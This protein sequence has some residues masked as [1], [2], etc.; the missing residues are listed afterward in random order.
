M[1]N[2]LILGDDFESI[3]LKIEEI[4]KNFESDFEF[5]KYDLKEDD[6]YQIVDDINTVS[7]FDSLKFV[8]VKNASEIENTSEK[9]LNEL[10][11]IMNNYNSN[12]VLVLVEAN[13]LD[14]KNEK[15]ARLKKYSTY[16]EIKTKNLMLDDLAKKI[17]DDNGYKYDIDAIDL[18]KDYSQNY[19]AIKNNLDILMMYKADTKEI[20]FK[21]INL[22]ITKPLDDNI[23][24]LVNAV[25]SKNKQSIFSHYN[26]LKTKNVQATYI[27]G[28]LINKFQEIYNV[29]ILAKSGMNQE[30]IAEIFNVSSGR[31]YYMIKN[32]RNTNLNEIKRNLDDLNELE[33]K[34]KSG[35]IDQTLGLELYFLK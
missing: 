32:T 6:L 16:I 28:L 20:T 26:D 25:L 15:I 11:K 12:N 1:F 29:F 33:F 4:K 14:L 27:L 10:L 17:L 34:I 24:D 8:I 35:V 5:S 9:K 31:A 13:K 3:N 7:L 22:M 18:L 19:T 2:Y 30:K 21:D 23:Y